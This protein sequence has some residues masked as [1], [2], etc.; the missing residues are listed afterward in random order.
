MSFRKDI[1]LFRHPRIKLFGTKLS[2]ST[3]LKPSTTVMLSIV[4][5]IASSKLIT[6][7]V[8]PKVFHSWQVNQ[9]SVQPPIGFGES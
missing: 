1:K 5:N 7:S 8:P 6:P 4:I 9:V 3:F 2:M